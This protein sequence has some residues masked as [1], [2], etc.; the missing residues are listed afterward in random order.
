MLHDH[1]HM[2]LYAIIHYIKHKNNVHKLT[3][4]P[5]PMYINIL[6]ICLNTSLFIPIHQYT[7]SSKIIIETW[8]HVRIGFSNCKY[9]K[10]PLFKNHNNRKRWF[11]PSSNPLEEIFTN[12]WVNWYTFRIYEAFKSITNTLQ[13]SFFRKMINKGYLYTIMCTYRFL[14]VAIQWYTHI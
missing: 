14:Q 4:S 3:Y 10:R 6:F 13:R 12:A 1:L 7:Q 5:I 2:C 9:K 11:K 8:K